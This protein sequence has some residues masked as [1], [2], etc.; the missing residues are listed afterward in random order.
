MV[1]ESGGGDQ[2]LQEVMIDAVRQICETD[3][4][5]VAAW[6]YGSFAWGEADAYSDI[7][8]LIYLDDDAHEAFEPLPWLSEIVPVALTF[9]NEHG[10][11]AVIFENLIRG[12]FHFERASDMP[13]L[14]AY[15]GTAGFP[16]PEAMFIYDRTGELMEHLR[17]ISGPGPERANAETAADL[18]HRFLN[19]MLFGVN[20][21]A[22][23]ERARAL[24]LLWFVQRHLLGMVRVVEGTTGHWLPP[25]RRAEQDLSPASYDRYVACTASLRGAE[26]ARAYAHA[27]TWGKELGR[28]LTIRFGIDLHG[29]LVDQLDARFA[30]V[31]A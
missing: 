2:L 28:D 17:S 23:G 12:E 13:E 14:R 26:L 21:L 27:W 22:R 24:E 20:V 11:Q 16:A 10:I 18:W 7:E 4:R 15:K 29:A 1:G 9:V 31:C 8:F 25:C 30:R 6:M 19:Q 5:V 3:D